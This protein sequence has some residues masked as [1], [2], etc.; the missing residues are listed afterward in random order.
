MTSQNNE[1]FKFVT[2]ATL[3]TI[4]GKRDIEPSYSSGE[5]PTGTIKSPDRPRL[6]LPDA[7]MSPNSIRLARGCADAYAVRL[8]HHNEDLHYKNCPRNL[9]ASLA[10]DALEQARCEALGFEEMKGVGSNLNAVLEEKC[11]RSGFENI[12]KADQASLPDA[13]HVLTRLELTGED[14]PPAAEK[15]VG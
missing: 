1:G 4:A 15:L 6:P 12:T 9:Q 13:L 5:T 7:D 10:F 14:T 2:S 11:K 3:R 8:A